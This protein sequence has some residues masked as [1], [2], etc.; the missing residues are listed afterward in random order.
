MALAL[1]CVMQKVL[2]IGTGFTLCYAKSVIYV[3]ALALPCVRLKVLFNGTGITLCYVES[4]DSSFNVEA[5]NAALV[6]ASVLRSCTNQVQAHLQGA[7]LAVV[8]L[9]PEQKTTFQKITV[10]FLKFH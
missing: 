8:V 4:D 10:N 3:M 9:D 7:V 1:H 2:F 5:G 6:L